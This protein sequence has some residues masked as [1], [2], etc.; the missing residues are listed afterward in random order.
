MQFS[1]GAGLVQGALGDLA[2][3][4]PLDCFQATWDTIPRTSCG[5]AVMFIQLVEKGKTKSLADGREE[6][7]CHKSSTPLEQYL[8]VLPFF[9]SALDFIRARKKTVP[10][11]S[12][13]VKCCDR[14]WTLETIPLIASETNLLF[15]FTRIGS[16]EGGRP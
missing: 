2:G 10:M 11:P 15:T 1:P 9:T 8:N 6:R 7:A 12:H 4:P 3:L 14:K 13:I 16:L 5:F